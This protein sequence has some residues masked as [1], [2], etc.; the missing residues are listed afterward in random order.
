[1]RPHTP[2]ARASYPPSL[3]QATINGSGSY[4]Y[5]VRVQ[6]LAESGTGADSI[7]RVDHSFAV[8]RPMKKPNQ[9]APV[10][11]PIAPR[12]QFEH[13]WRRVTEQRRS[14]PGVHADA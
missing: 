9:S 1:M 3:G 5:R 11:A 7:D 4:L 14:A 10:N 12:F 6:D 13:L 8:F 2:N